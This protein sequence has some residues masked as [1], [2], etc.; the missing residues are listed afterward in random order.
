MKERSKFVLAWERRWNA[1]E[2]AEEGAVALE[3]RDEGR[4]ERMRRHAHDASMLDACR[5]GSETCS[6][7]LRP[8]SSWRSARSLRS[9][10]GRSSCRS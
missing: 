8:P 4:Q 1:A 5:A 6:M 10:V 2:G 7:L 9:L 3:A